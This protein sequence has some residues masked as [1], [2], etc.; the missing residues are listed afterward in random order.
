MSSDSQTRVTFRSGAGRNSWTVRVVIA[1]AALGVFALV[2]TVSVLLFGE[3]A[4]VEFS[5][6]TFARRRFQYYEL[7]L[8]RY[9]I[10]GVYHE[11]ITGP[12]EKRLRGDEQLLPPSQ[13]QGQ[14]W[15]L[16]GM[17]R[18]GTIYEDDAQIVCRYFNTDDGTGPRWLRWNRQHPELAKI[19]WPAVA[20]ACRADLYIFVPRLLAT[21]ER[22]TTATSQPPGEEEFQRAIDAAMASQY[23]MLAEAKQQLEAHEEAIELYSAVLD[24][25]ADNVAALRGRAFSYFAVGEDEK[26]AADRQRA[27]SLARD[28]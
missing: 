21:A 1:V 2:A 19:L 23:L 27:K 12:L 20:Q 10:G 24:R 16:V 4:G 26:S 9:R 5:P 3:V 11:D 6:D 22:L 14:R 15:D 28:E 25:D 13:R 17:S 18:G 8:L 7:P